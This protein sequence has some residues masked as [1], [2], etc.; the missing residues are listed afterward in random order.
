MSGDVHVRFCE[1]LR[2]R[3]PWVTRLCGLFPNRGRCETILA[4][5]GRATQS[6]WFRNSAG[7]NLLYRVW[8]VCHKAG[9]ARSEKAATFDFLGF[10]HY[11]CSRSRNGQ[12]F[13]MKRKTISKRLTAKLKACKGWLKSNRALTTPDIIQKTV[14]KLRGHYGYY[15]IT[16]NSQGI[17]AYYYEVR[18]ML[19]KWLNRRG[20]RGCY[21]WEK[22][23]KL[24]RRYPLPTPRIMVNLFLLCKMVLM[25]SRVRK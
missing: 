17:N 9:K 8:S 3:F 21:S 14:G 10:T 20:K 7:E 13:R 24:L 18:G 2:G 11:C 12:R 4:Y 22:F 19:Y 5:D 16:D 25:K 23:T 15:R 1:N 6:V